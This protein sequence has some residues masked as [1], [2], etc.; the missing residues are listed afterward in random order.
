MRAV[1]A[2]I[3]L[4]V[5]IQSRPAHGAEPASRSGVPVHA[6]AISHPPDTKGPAPTVEALTHDRGV[7]AGLAVVPGVIAHG[8]G[9]YALGQRQTA[10]ALLLSE[11]IGLALVIGG[12]STLRATGNSRYLAGPALAATVF[13]A[14]LVLAS[15]GADLYGTLATDGDAVDSIP[16]APPRFE[17]EFGYRY[18]A[19]PRF[20]YG[21]FVVES[22]TLRE[23][24]FRLAPS[25]WFATDSSNVRYRVEAAY[26]VLGLEPGELG[27][28]DD[29]LDLVLGGLHQRYLPEH[30]QRSGLEFTLDARFELAHLGDTLR[31]SFVD[32]ALGYGRARV[33][34]DLVGLSVPTDTDDLLLARVGLGVL[35][36]GRAAPGSEAKLYYD[37]R[38]DDYA[39]GFF[40][41]GRISGVFGK[42]GA[43]FRWF[44]TPRL[45]VLLDAQVGSAVVGGVSL[46]MRDDNRN[47]GRAP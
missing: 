5:A 10:F 42:F 4:F 27:K 30:F 39:A 37:H 1:A 41:P 25:A 13:G 24:R 19:D 11:G 6:A 29:H 46:L 9:H 23:G 47:T 43:D 2:S 7:A 33:K 31:G 12:V 3:L 26:R 35:L 40:T 17:S 28:R 20:S 16:R 15:F 21:H 22:L 8:S 45:G 18:V 44:F 38:H 36:R 14:G 32:L 34:Y